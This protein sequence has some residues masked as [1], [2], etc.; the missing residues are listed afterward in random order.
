M[1]DDETLTTDSTV[2]SDTVVVATLR[3]PTPVAPFQLKNYVT[4]Q[5]PPPLPLSYPLHVTTTLYPQLTP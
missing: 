2:V 3:N 4:P 1:L 5:L